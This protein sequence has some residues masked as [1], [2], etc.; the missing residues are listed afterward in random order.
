MFYVDVSEIDKAD[1]YEY[2]ETIR[3]HFNDYF[4][5]TVKTLLVATR[6]GGNRVECINPKLLG[7]AEYGR[8]ERIVNTFEE[9]YQKLIDELKVDEQ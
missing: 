4:D 7:A 3:K 9:E 1:V 5:S 6:E 2:I 8:V